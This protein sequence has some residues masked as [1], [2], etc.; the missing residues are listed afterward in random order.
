MPV[1]SSRLMSETNRLPMAVSC[2]RVARSQHG[3]RL[4]RAVRPTHGGAIRMSGPSRRPQ[5][6]QTLTDRSLAQAG[7]RQI[8]REAGL[9][10]RAERGGTASTFD[11]RVDT[12]RTAAIDVPTFP[13]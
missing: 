6:A 1:T 13:G 3:R 2:A 12:R 8:G 10:P 9:T 7:Y 11:I 5:S 4:T